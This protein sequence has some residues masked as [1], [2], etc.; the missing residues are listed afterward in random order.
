MRPSWQ[1]REKDASMPGYNRIEIGSFSNE[2][3]SGRH[4]ISNEIHGYQRVWAQACP[5]DQG[6]ACPRASMG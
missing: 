3:D 4:S 5:I 2:L 1:V 6:A